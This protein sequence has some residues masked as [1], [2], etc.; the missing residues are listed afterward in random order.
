MNTI[1]KVEHLKKSFGKHEVLHDI[2]FTVHENEIVGFVG[3]NGSGKS[4]TMKCI[5]GL[6]KF[7]QGD[8]RVMDVDIKTKY[9]TCLK[10]MG[11]S[12]ENPALYPDLNGYDH[13]LMVAR[14]RNVNKKDLQE[15]YEFS[16]LHDA[17]KKPIKT[18]SMG[19]KQ[20][21]MLSLCL[22]GS[23]KLLLLDEPMN[24][25]DPQATFELREKL[26]ALKQQNK[27]ILLSSHQLGE[28]E[29]IC[30]TIIFIKEGTIIEEIHASD[31]TQKHGYKFSLEPMDKALSICERMHIP[32]R[33]DDSKLCVQFEDTSNFN[34]FLKSLMEEKIT[35]L[36]IA[37]ENNH[38]EEYYKRL[39]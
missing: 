4:T 33:M 6:Y 29:K 32:T 27:G 30:D 13:F 37:Y 11:V 12:I 26:L 16:G 22:V 38:L 7:E 1:C 36:H 34:D 2:S 17:L 24:G 25:L 19:M 21:L 14:W 5:S 15:L 20:R 10:E 3:P 18:Y 28:I 31:L 23:P 35:I 8:I 9:S 39:Y